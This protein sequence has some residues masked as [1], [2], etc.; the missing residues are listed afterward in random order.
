MLNKIL[1]T[2]FVVSVVMG[3]ARWRGNRAQAPMV[4]INPQ[5]RPAARP[6][7]AWVRPAAYGFAALV[8]TASALWYYTSWQDGQQ[9]VIIRV[10]NTSSGESASYQ[11]RKGSIDGRSFRTTDGFVVRVA[12]AE[13][14][15]VQ[16]LD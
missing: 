1:F 13:R 6:L 8:V 10:I 14:I 9:V 5:A 3:I 16:D 11:A 4:T 7:P 15:E 12:D 2:V